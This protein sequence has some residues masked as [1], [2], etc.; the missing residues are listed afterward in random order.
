MLGLVSG[1]F[2]GFVMFFY[3]LG[4]DSDWYCK[5]HQVKEEMELKAVL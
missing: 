5:D 3:M 4:R 2:F 1:V